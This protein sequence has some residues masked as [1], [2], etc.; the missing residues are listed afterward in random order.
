MQDILCFFSEPYPVLRRGVI[1]TTLGPY[2][3]GE[4]D[5]TLRDVLVTDS[6]M[7]QTLRVVKSI[8]VLRFNS[9]KCLAIEEAD[10]ALKPERM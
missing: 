2:H 4:A 9:E 1:I 6:G 3:S 10:R 5:P 7:A 8:R